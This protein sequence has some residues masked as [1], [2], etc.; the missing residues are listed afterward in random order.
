MPTDINVFPL[1]NKVIVSVFDVQICL[2]IFGEGL[3][4]R[5]LVYSSEL[6]GGSHP[7]SRASEEGL[8]H[9]SA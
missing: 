3:V 1:V 8:L 5:P 7:L 9:W 4:L 6:P 2:L